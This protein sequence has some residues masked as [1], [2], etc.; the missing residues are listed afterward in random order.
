MLSSPNPIT[1]PII[2]ISGYLTKDESATPSIVSSISSAAQSP[3]FLQITG[4]GIAPELTTRLLD[5]LKAFFALPLEKKTALHRNNSAA[6]R[7]FEAVGE[8][9]LEKGV[10]DSKEGFMIGPEWVAQNGKETRFLQGPNQWPADTDVE[11]LRAVMMEYFG[12]MQAL[13]KTM[14]RLVALGLGLEEGYFDG[15][16]GSE[17]CECLLF[18]SGTFKIAVSCS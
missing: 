7:G 11:G 12:E 17:D 10:M 6:L 16:V 9:S 13:S 1:I 14:F 5:H 2:D 15:F 3:G 18:F 4:H 8:Q